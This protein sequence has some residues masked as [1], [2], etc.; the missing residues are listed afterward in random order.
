VNL[1]AADITGLGHQVGGHLRAFCHGGNN[2]DDMVVGYA[3]QGLQSGNK[4][5]GVADRVSSTRDPVPAEPTTTREVVLPFVAEDDTYRRAGDCSH[6]P[7]L[8]ARDTVVG[9]GLGDDHQRVWALGSVSFVVRGARSEGV[10]DGGLGLTE[11]VPSDR[12]SS[13]VCATLT[14][15]GAKRSCTG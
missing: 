3:L 2:V 15:S 4:Y 6:D 9:G 11:F 8:G 13:H 12:G 14:C 1:Q 7:L 10:I 5:V